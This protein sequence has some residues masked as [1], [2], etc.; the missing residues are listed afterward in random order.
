[1]KDGT[2]VTIANPIA[3]VLSGLNVSMVGSCTP[4]AAS[5]TATA[6]VQAGNVGMSK[7]V[8][9]SATAVRDRHED[10]L[11]RIPG[12]VGTGIGA[13]DQP[14]QPAIVVYVKKMTPEAQAAAPKE[15]EGVP[16]KLIANG[17]FI[18]Y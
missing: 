5:E 14:G 3:A 12:A 15:M 2:P 17:G 9:K 13:S 10:E 7:E 8:V 1:M 11:M 18:A 4:A 16:V 6:D